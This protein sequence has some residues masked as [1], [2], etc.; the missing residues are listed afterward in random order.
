MLGGQLKMSS[1]F[2]RGDRIFEDTATVIKVA[3]GKIYYSCDICNNELSMAEIGYENAKDK[4]CIKCKYGTT[5]DICKAT[6]KKNKRIREKKE[7]AEQ[8]KIDLVE[9]KKKNKG[10]LKVVKEVD[11]LDYEIECEECGETYLYRKDKFDDVKVPMCLK[12]GKRG[13]YINQEGKKFGSII[14]VRELGG[15]EVEC[16]CTKCGLLDTYN[17]SRVKNRLIKCKACKE[18]GEEDV[19]LVGSI[20]NDLYVVRD[21]L[22]DTL[23]LKVYC[24]ICGRL[25]K[26]SKGSLLLKTS[27][28]GCKHSEVMISCRYCGKRTYKINLKDKEIR[29]ENEFCPGANNLGKFD[30]E[31]KV[32]I[33]TGLYNITLKEEYNTSNINKLNFSVHGDINGNKCLVIFKK[34]IYLGRDRLEYYRCYCL[35][36]KKYILLAANEVGW[37][38]NTKYNHEVCGVPFDM[39]IE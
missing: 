31:Y 6:M 24:L 30:D 33:A 19:D 18:S 32:G 28:C 1:K 36:H 16:E 22:K 38:G 29:C 23:D 20:I 2:K 17:K 7:K 15:G 13:G 39:D 34:P 10:R 27:E 14:I 3:G 9:Y 11:D 21:Q 8:D 35:S 25:M 26:K 4:M 5:R 12:C 37:D